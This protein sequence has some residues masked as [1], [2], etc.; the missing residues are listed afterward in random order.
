MVDEVVTYK[1]AGVIALA[2]TALGAL[3]MFLWM[4]AGTDEGLQQLREQLEEA[5]ARV[6]TAERRAEESGAAADEAFTAH[7]RLVA[8]TTATVARLNQEARVASVQATELADSIKATVNEETGQRIEQ[9][10]MQWQRVVVQEQAEKD[11]WRERA[12]SAERGWADERLYVT[13]LEMQVEAQERQL[14]AQASLV[15]ALEVSARRN[16][17]VKRALVVAGVGLAIW[18]FTRSPT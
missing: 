1:K 10:A 4:N 16:K 17:R 2:C 5:D 3:V 15:E 8:E 13:A 12:L 11:L 6:A 9:L 14:S 18:T 7:T